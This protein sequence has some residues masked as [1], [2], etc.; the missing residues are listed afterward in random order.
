MMFTEEKDTFLQ[1]M[2]N[3]FIKVTIV[4]SYF[5]NN[6]KIG[7]ETWQ[8]IVEPRQASIENAKTFLDDYYMNI[9]NS[10]FTEEVKEAYLTKMTS[11]EGKIE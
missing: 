9:V 8:C 10:V 11:E 3:K 7:E 2:P 6:V 5:K 4:S 1:V